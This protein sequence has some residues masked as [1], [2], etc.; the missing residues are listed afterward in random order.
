MCVLIEKGDPWEQIWAYY[1][2]ERIKGMD[3][4]MLIEKRDIHKQKR[5]KKSIN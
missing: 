4:D 5:T 3:M 1:L 2:N